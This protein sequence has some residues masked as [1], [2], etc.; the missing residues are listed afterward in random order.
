MDNVLDENSIE[1]TTDYV[2][3]KLIKRSK[4]ESCMILLKAGDFDDIAKMHN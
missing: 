1:V 4:C 2:A 3:K